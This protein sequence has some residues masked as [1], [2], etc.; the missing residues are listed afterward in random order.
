MQR[1][2]AAKRGQDFM[3][4][5][6]SNSNQMGGRY[7]PS[8]EPTARTQQVDKPSY[9]SRSSTPV[10][11]AKGMKLGRKAKAA[12]LFDAIKPDVEEPLLRSVSSAPVMSNQEVYVFYLLF[13]HACLAKYKYVCV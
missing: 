13:L 5:N 4:G 8:I 2:E 6:F 9:S 11:Q 3:Q 1:K 12:D 7:S 10:S